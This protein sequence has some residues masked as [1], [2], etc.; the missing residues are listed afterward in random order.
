MKQ[1]LDISIGQRLTMAFGLL[2]LLLGVFV[3]F[4]WSWHADSVRA[5]ERLSEEIVPQ[6]SQIS[7]MKYALLNVGIA[8]R[9]Y[10][11]QPEAS[12]LEQ[13]RSAVEAA[14]ADLRRVGELAERSQ[15][16]TGDAYGAAAREIERFLG[17]AN[18][19]AA[20]R[21]AR[22]VTEAEE[23]VLAIA[24]T[25]AVQ[26]LHEFADLQNRRLAVALG[27]MAAARDNV[28]KGLLTASG[29]ALIFLALVGFFTV[30]SIRRPTR[31]L[32]S[33]AS[34]LEAGDWRPALAWAPERSRGAESMAPARNEIFKLGRAFGAAAAALENREQ[35]MRADALVASAAASSLQKEA[36]A[37]AA[38][39]GIAKHVHAEVGVMYWRERDSETLLPVARHALNGEAVPLRIGE[40][41]PGQAAKERQVLVTRDIPRDSAFSVR[42]GYDQAPPKAVAAVPITF[43]EELRGAVL[44]ASLRDFD[45]DALSFLRAAGLQL[46]IGFQNAY[47]HEQTERLLAEVR[48]KNEHIQ[49]QNEE[50]QAQNEEIQAQSE[51][52]QAQSE[53]IQAQSEEILAQNDDL[54]QQAEDLRAHAAA[55]TEAG[56]RKSE[57]L[58]VL[59]H[60]LRNPLA[61]ITNSLII[62]KRAPA[63]S[64]HSLRA[65]TVI[66]RQAQQLVR[67]IDDLLDIT[68]ISQGKINIQRDRLDLTEVVRTC[69]EDLGAELET[70][71]LAVELEVPDSAVWVEGDQARLCQILGNLMNNAIKFN[72]KGKTITVSLQTN[73]RRGYAVLHVIDRGIGIDAELLPQLFRSFN[74]GVIAPGRTNTGLGLGLALVKELAE[75]HGGSVEARSAGRGKGAEFIVRL[76]LAKAETV[77]PASN[78]ADAGR[79]ILVVED[80]L[81]VA[82][83]LRDVLTLEGHEVELAHSGAEALA[84]AP[85]FQPEVVLCDI[86]LPEMDGY[87]V[88][89]QLRADE[90]VR[91]VFLVALTGY[92]SQI[93]KDRAAEAGFDFHLAKPPSIESIKEILAAL[94]Q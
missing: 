1:P 69:I 77:E 38:L 27:T 37:A 83:T 46:G 5:E 47:A 42:L 21:T 20:L 61:A 17:E 63:G 32:L 44:V 82:H 60:E 6:V 80:N 28:S 14:R 51:E 78:D 71:G 64:E 67:L 59:A 74:Q 66:E 79:R 10:I 85:V 18:R 33:V 72:D 87:E 89:R 36:I 52:I 9:A 3:G 19:V 24:R 55:L 25:D 62:V 53:E 26:R 48:D 41:I 70:N 11:M 34:A 31:R 2:V 30:R 43:G 84:R 15:E 65:Q 68:R 57:F 73:E 35:R 50:L 94:S 40:G 88:V 54:K 90:R 22:R 93:D 13:Q 45:D 76:P 58:G 23:Q 86:G 49:S 16:E 29:L 56:A 91:P 7:A 12:R 92:A 81:D 39:S 8:T 4:V 75:L